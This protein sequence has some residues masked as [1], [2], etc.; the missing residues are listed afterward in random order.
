MCEFNQYREIYGLLL[1]KRKSAGKK[2]VL[3]QECKIKTPM[4][5]ARVLKLKKHGYHSIVHQPIFF[6]SIAKTA[7]CD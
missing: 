6:D 5:V 2:S 7:I 1:Y 3:L 4:F